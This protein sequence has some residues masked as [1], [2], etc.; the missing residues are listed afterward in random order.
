MEL[1]VLSAS[2]LVTLARNK[3][4]MATMSFSVRWSISCFFILEPDDSL[5]AHPCQKTGADDEYCT[6][7]RT[8]G[9]EG[10][11]DFHC[12]VPRRR[13][14]GTTSPADASRLLRRQ[15]RRGTAGRPASTRAACG[16]V[17]GSV[18]K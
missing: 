1:M 8:C 3:A 10:V 18:I 12:C 16:A 13:G 11:H 15:P 7:T 2:R 17:R 5:A 6:A 4:T 9:C 14:A